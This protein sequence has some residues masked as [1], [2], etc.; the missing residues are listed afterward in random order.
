[1]TQPEQ[2]TDEIVDQVGLVTEQST[3]DQFDRWVY[4]PTPDE[5]SGKFY[6]S[7]YISRADLR[8]RP[9]SRRFYVPAGYFA[10]LPL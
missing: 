10:E 3:I 5:P 8:R 4:Y 9:T 1:V 2:V 7:I 6:L